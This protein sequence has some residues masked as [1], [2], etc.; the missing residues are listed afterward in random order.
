MSAPAYALFKRSYEHEK[1]MMPEMLLLVELAADDM[2]KIRKR[3]IGTLLSLRYKAPIKDWEE[4]AYY[5]FEAAIRDMSL[6][7]EVFD[8][9]RA[10]L[11][12]RCEARWAAESVLEKQL[13][14]S[15]FLEERWPS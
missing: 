15:R 1:Q 11:K 6:V 5:E 8:N 10:K 4:V 14:R 2:I 3:I 13:Y 7:F 9:T 12:A